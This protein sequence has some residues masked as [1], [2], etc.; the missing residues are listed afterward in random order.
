MEGLTKESIISEVKKLDENLKESKK[1]FKV[2]TIL[3]AALKVGANSKKIAK[4][5]EIPIEEITEYEKNLRKN[6]VWVKEQTQCDWFGKDGGVFFWMDVNVALGF[7][8][9]SNE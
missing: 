4:L 6:N 2:A 9:K 5:L 3:I 7:M 8:E 1:S